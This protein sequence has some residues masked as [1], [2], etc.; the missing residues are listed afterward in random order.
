MDS[1]GLLDDGPCSSRLNRLPKLALKPWIS[2]QSGNILLTDA[3]V[4]DPATGKLLSG[5]HSV[6]IRGGVIREVSGQPIL[7]PDCNTINLNGLFIC[8]LVS[9]E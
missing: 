6:L 5:R 9:M 2:S 7:A 1:R 3:Q 8:P 4:I